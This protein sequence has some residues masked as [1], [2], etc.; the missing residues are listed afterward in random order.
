L[1][2]EEPPGWKEMKSISH[3]DYQISPG[4]QG[5]LDSDATWF[6]PH[7]LHQYQTGPETDEAPV[8]STTAIIDQDHP[9]LSSP[10][11]SSQAIQRDHSQFHTQ[12]PPVMD[13]SQFRRKQN[14]SKNPEVTE[15]YEW[16][17][18]PPV[19][20]EKQTARAQSPAALDIESETLEWEL[21][22]P[23]PAKTIQKVGY[24]GVRADFRIHPLS[25]M[26]R[27]WNAMN[28]QQAKLP[29]AM[30]LLRHL[31]MVKYYFKKTVKESDVSFRTK[32]S[33]LL[34]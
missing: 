18:T 23:R 17:A 31:F 30:T 29:L 3:K 15:D 11:P 14:E 26:M 21:T 2:K 22:P 34:Q 32:T 9:P 1:N 5:M 10:E 4:Q 28:H 27:K 7:N 33:C 16:E 8:V 24:Y 20:K 19:A 13:E 12:A 6:T 25:T